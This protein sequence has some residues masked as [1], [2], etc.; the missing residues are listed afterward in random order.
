M[1][2][3]ARPER[4]SAPVHQDVLAVLPPEPTCCRHCG[5]RVEHVMRGSA[6]Q[7]RC[8]RCYAEA[9][10]NWTGWSQ[11]V[12]THKPADDGTPAEVYLRWH[13]LEKLKRLAR[14]AA[15]RAAGT[16]PTPRE[17]VVVPVDDAVQAGASMAEM[18]A[19]LMARYER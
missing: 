19:R 7:F 5:G 6:D 2:Q 15:Q 10:A 16:R 4:L 8:L 13:Q 12:A 3:L 18:T 9:M 11:A 14:Q 17:V 1:I